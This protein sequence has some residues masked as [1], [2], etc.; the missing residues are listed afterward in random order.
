MDSTYQTPTHLRTSN[1]ILWGYNDLCKVTQVVNTKHFLISQS[2][3]SFDGFCLLG[4]QSFGGRRKS[5]ELRTLPTGGRREMNGIWY[6]DLNQCEHPLVADLTMQKYE[7][8]DFAAVGRL[9]KVDIEQLRSFV[10]DAQ[11]GKVEDTETMANLAFLCQKFS[12]VVCSNLLATV[13][14]YSKY[15]NIRQSLDTIQ[16]MPS[17]W[18]FVKTIWKQVHVNEASKCSQKVQI[19]RTK[20]SKL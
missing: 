13:R 15:S 10:S 14:K 18:M 7:R 20:T 17:H 2:G 4:S 12:A 1:W 8:H 16:R 6:M 3:S 5:P 19:Q 11:W 9:L